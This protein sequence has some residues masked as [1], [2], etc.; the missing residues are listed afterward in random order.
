MPNAA[1]S[2]PARLRRQ[3]TAARAPTTCSK[4]TNELKLALGTLPVVSQRCALHSQ[5]ESAMASIAS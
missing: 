5:I 2:G 4:V 3:R 1:A